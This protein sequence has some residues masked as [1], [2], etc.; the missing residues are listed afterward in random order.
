MMRL[1]F[2][3]VLI[4]MLIIAALVALFMVLAFFVIRLFQSGRATGSPPRPAAE[5]PLETL[6]RRLAAG[7]ITPEQYDD[8]RRRLEE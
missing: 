5:T 2:L 8:L 7:E 6:R 1:G 4:I 3:E